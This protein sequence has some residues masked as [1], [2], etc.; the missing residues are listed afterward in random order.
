VEKS[1][2]S[3]SSIFEAI[4]TN[5]EKTPFFFLALCAEELSFFFSQ[6]QQKEL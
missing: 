5:M 3:A 6:Y 4:S 1:G 2:K